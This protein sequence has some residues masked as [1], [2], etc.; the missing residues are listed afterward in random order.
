MDFAGGEVATRRQYRRCRRTSE[1]IQDAEGVAGDERIQG[2][3]HT[4]ATA[5][6]TATAYTSA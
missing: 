6:T 4:A 2:G 5:A 3:R 1:R